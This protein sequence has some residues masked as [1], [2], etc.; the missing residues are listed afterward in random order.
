MKIYKI[1][2]WL[3]G[4][5]DKLTRIKYKRGM[6]KIK[7]EPKI[8][9]YKRDEYEKAVKERQEDIRR[10]YFEERWPQQKIADTLGMDLT[11]VNRF[12]RKIEK[13]QG[14]GLTSDN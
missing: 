8:F 10:L 9:E 4:T 6:P 3:V 1:A 13:E 11:Q 5:L 14:Q 12:V 7:T 2:N